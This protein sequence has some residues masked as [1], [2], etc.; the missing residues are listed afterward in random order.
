MFRSKAIKFFIH[1]AG[2]LIF[3]GFPLLFMNKTQET[4]SNSFII[5]QSPFY[6]LFCLTYI[7]MFYLNAWYLVPKLVFNKKYIS[8]GIIILLLLGCVY[9]LQPFDNL[10]ENNLFKNAKFATSQT[11][12]GSPGHDASIPN[13]GSD[14]ASPGDKSLPFG[15]LPHQD[16]RMQDPRFKSSNKIIF[17]HQSGNI[18]MVGLFIFIIVIG[19][20]IAISTVQK[21]QL[22][23]RMVVRA[24]AEKA[25]AELSFLKAQINPHF[26][27]NTLNNIYA[28]SVTDSE[29]TS[30]S[31]MKLSNIMRYVT[32]EVT[33]D[34]VLLQSEIDC[35][36]DYIDLQKLRLGKKTQLNFTITGH[37][38][39]QKIAPLVLMTFIENV[40][41]Y[42]VSKHEQSV[43]D[44]NLGV[45]EKKISFFCQNPIFENGT[46][47][48][49]RKGI[50]I[51]NTKRRLQ[52]I[53]PGK[54]K[55]NISTN[56]G[57][58]TVNLEIDS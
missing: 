45:D 36:N 14:T 29:H 17:I 9:F 53:Y 49:K 5:I 2:W 13:I 30:E 28:L 24:E 18:D 6:W 44:I 57:L 8:Y 19:L 54:H 7:F 26:L 47:T 33:E 12:M 48:N 34:Y 40:F 16:M 22:T 52:H 56:D 43:I 3:L 32:D 25:H 50:G 15:P 35:I 38:L 21:W 31:I 27:F 4:R 55:L 11:A 37:I 39:N 46:S 20:S 51:S 10:L 58:F 42:G 41:K 1:A 23:E